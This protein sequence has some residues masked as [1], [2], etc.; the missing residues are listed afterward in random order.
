M[1][2]RATIFDESSLPL[3]SQLDLLVL[4]SAY[5]GGGGGAILGVFVFGALLAGVSTLGTASFD[6]TGVASFFT[7][8]FLAG[9]SV[10]E[11]LGW[12]TARAQRLFS[13]AGERRS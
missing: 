10:T 12:V 4:G 3:R 2:D 7:V 5:L 11:F 9:F 6:T 8:A 1:G 13:G